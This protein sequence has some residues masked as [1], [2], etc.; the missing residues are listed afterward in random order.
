MLF[1]PNPTVEQ[2][3]AMASLNGIAFNNQLWQNRARHHITALRLEIKD[4][5][6][7][8]FRLYDF[9]LSMV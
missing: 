2:L 7:F 6:Q 4:E 1:T 9:Y 5:W 3:L 8:L